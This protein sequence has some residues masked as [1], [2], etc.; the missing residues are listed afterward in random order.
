MS[1]NL[2][3]RKFSHMN[4]VKNLPLYIKIPI[5]LAVFLA[6][7]LGFVT[8][9]ENT[10]EDNPVTASCKIRKSGDLAIGGEALSLLSHLYWDPRGYYVVA[11]LDQS[12]NSW[13]VGKMGFAAD[14]DPYWE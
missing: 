4:K 2:T 1:P 12:K 3:V 14:L 10:S 11:G 8:V 9:F 13:L 7:V 6:L 5:I